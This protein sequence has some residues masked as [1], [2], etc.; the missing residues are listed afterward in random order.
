MWCTPG[1][2]KRTIA[3][4]IFVYDLKKL[5]KLH[6]PVMFA[7][8]TNSFYIINKN[9]K[10]LFQTVNKELHY[11]NEWFIANKLN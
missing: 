11:V 1:F 6:N 3:F 9:F 7:D 8:D 4:F 2:Y 5:T 10:V